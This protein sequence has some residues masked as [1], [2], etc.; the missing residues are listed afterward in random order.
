MNANPLGILGS[1][2]AMAGFLAAYKLTLKRSRG[3]RALWAAV[4]TLAALPAVW[5][6][7]YYLHVVPESVWLYEVRSWRG[8]E[9]LAVFAGIAGGCLAAL[10][11]RWLLILPLFASLAVVMPPY[12]KPIVAPLD[13]SG[14][15]DSWD[16]EVC[17]QSTEATCGPA[18]VATILRQFGMEAQEGE[19]AKATHTA[20]R[21]T[22]AWYLARYVRS[23]GLAATFEMRP[24]FDTGVALPALAGVRLDGT[25]HFIPLLESRDG[26]LHVG[27][28]VEGDDWLTPEEMQERYQFTG[29]YLC[30]RR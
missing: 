26:R 23:R 18:S 8:T 12:L 16:A 13:M 27:D 5:F 9:L 1:A 14:L 22:E 7:A 3:Q 21:G 6:A 29:F 4:A 10:L 15:R 20:R 25:G 24:G 19:V 28:P 17:L 11:P 30:I 2:L